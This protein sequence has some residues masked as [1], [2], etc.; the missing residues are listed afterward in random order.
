MSLGRPKKLAEQSAQ[1]AKDKEKDKK[2][3]VKEDKE[4]TA[5]MIIAANN[6]SEL[7]AASAA[8]AAKPA[9]QSFAD[10]IS[11]SFFDLTSSSSDRLQ[12]WKSKLHSAGSSSRKSSNASA[13]RELTAPSQR[14]ND[15]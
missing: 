4:T 10:K 11:R 2:E 1:L 13:D 12:K 7:P 5:K 6:N 15:K 8:A 9:N 14:F 3:K